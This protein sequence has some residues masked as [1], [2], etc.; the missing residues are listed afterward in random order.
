MATGIQ[1]IEA[2]PAERKRNDHMRRKEWTVS[3]LRRRENLG[4]VCMFQ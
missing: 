3:P 1:S 2:S 4:L